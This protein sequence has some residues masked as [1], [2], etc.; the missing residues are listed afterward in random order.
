MTTLEMAG[1]PD[2]AVAKPHPILKRI[3]IIAL[4]AIALGFAMQGLIL[5][6]KMSSG[7]PFPGARLLVDLAQG[8]TWSFLVCTGVGI[9]TSIMKARAALVGLLGL[10]CAPL[11]IA[12]A[13]SSQKVMASMVGAADQP[14]ILSLATI[15]G[16]RAIEYGLLGWWL[17]TL[18][19]REVSRA[20]PYLSAGA[21][22]GVTFGGAIAVLTYHVA[23]SKGLAP[24]L[25]QILGT[26]VNEVVFPI[27][28]AFV[29]YI[30]QLISQ[31]VR[32]EVK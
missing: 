12:A 2:D 4:C 24:A 9:G 21:L 6:V 22:L 17:G 13:K 8:V 26:V 30:G 1:V 28:C 7:A 23:V 14:V 18:A 11:A 5:V 10:I 31:H 32:M 3:A 27:G 15:S 19:R 29:I 25:P 20:V 16:L